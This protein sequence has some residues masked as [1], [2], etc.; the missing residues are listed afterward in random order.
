M[1]N[2]GSLEFNAERQA[3]SKK[4]RNEQSNTIPV[5]GAA[6]SF[7]SI[8]HVHCS[9]GFSFGV[10]TK[11]S[12]ILHNDGEEVVH[13]IPSFIVDILTDSLDSPSPGKPPDSSSGQRSPLSLLDFAPLDSFS[14]NF[15]FSSH[16]N[17]YY[18]QSNL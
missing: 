9:D 10:L 11:D 15:S 13:E 4:Y 3:G 12:S 8:D 16:F 7:E 1:L 18:R 2:I 17:N 6:A 14:S 5:D